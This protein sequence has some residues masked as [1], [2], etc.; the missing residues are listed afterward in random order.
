MAK[1]DPQWLGTPDRYARLRAIESLDLDTDYREITLLFYADFQ[2]AMFLKSW[3]GFMFTYAAP[4]ISAVLS[5]TGE[6][7]DR[8]PKRVVD[9]TLL[10]SAVMQ[11]GFS[12]PDGRDAARRVNAMHRQYDIAAQDF[13]AVGAEEAVGSL[14]LAERFGWRPVTDKEREAVR[15]YYSHQTRA[16]G[17][18]V[19]LPDSVPEL[20]AFFSNY[21]DT[22]VHYEPQNERL[23]KIFLDW[24]VNLAPAAVRPL[25]RSMLIA[26]LDPRIAAACGLKQPRQPARYLA[27]KLQQSRASKDPVPDGVENGLETLVRGV[28][29]DGWAVAELGTHLDR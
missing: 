13:V 15:R 16:F 26:E 23:G 6:V 18:P 8:L 20:R 1:T 27:A 11:H 22:E 25:F 5:Q 3:H 19:P 14:E 9:T 29:P 12:E 17:S 10:A 7:V 21:L 28:Y 24:F 2:S 4:R